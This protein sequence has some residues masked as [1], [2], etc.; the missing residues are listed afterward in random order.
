MARRLADTARDRGARMTATKYE[1][2]ER[3]A[4][5]RADVVRSAL[6]ALTPLD[7]MPA[8]AEP[9]PV[10]ADASGDKARHD[11]GQRDSGADGEGDREAVG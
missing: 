5:E 6:L 10:A 2:R 8:S 4:A 7:E 3:T 9:P 11:V 1:D